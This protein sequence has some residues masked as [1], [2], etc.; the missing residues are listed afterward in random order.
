MCK[1]FAQALHDC[2]FCFYHLPAG[3]DKHQG[4]SGSGKTPGE[5]SPQQG[6]G[7]RAVAFQHGARPGR[8]AHVHSDLSHGT[9]YLVL[10]R[11]D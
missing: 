9:L 7:H 2:G 6:L 4:C 1:V 11:M 10:K 5:Q 3:E 8:R